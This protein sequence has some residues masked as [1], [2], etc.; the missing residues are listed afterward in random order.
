V[1]TATDYLLSLANTGRGSA[2]TEA[3][4]PATLADSVTIWPELFRIARNTERPMGTRKQALFWLGQAAGDVVAPDP[5]RGGHDSDEDEVRKSA[6]FALSQQ[7]NGEAV[8]ALI[9]VA[10]TN[11]SPAVRRN[12]LFWLGQTTDP[13]AIS[14]FEEILR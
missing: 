14:L 11:K 1:K 13:R 2:A 6:V 8:P 9:Q 3:I 10:R 7:R 4:L 12:A 5:S